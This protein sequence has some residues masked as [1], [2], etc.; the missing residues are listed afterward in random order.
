MAVIKFKASKPKLSIPQTPSGEVIV[1]EKV[2]LIKINKN[3]L[4]INPIMG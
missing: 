4:W 2:I 3:K 1:D